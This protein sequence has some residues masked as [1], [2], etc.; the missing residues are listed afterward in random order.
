MSFR[1]LEDLEGERRRIQHM[2]AILQGFRW[3]AELPVMGLK[4]LSSFSCFSGSYLG[5]ALV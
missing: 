4:S 1:K 3:D 5:G 2:G